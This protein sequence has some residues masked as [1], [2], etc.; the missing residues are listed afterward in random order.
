METLR[1][2]TPQLGFPG[3]DG[4]GGWTGQAEFR[5]VQRPRV[6]KQHGTSEKLY[7]VP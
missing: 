4:K 1:E 3:K 7:L 2:E 6:Q 5:Q